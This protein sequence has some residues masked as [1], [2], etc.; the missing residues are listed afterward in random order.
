[1]TSDQIFS[2]ISL[3]TRFGLFSYTNFLPLGEAT[4]PPCLPLATLLLGSM[5][6]NLPRD[7]QANVIFCLRDIHVFKI[8]ENVGFLYVF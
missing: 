7:F 3:T 1:M 5:M 4:A 2:E 6:Q 8:S